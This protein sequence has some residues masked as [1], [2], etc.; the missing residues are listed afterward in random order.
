MPHPHGVEL[1][2]LMQMLKDTE[3]RTVRSALSDDF[4]RVS[5]RRR[6]IY[7]EGRPRSE[8]EPDPH[9]P[10]RKRGTLPGDPG[11]QAD[12]SADGLPVADR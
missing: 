8:G 4:S 11:H 9:R 1:G 2:M 6:W 3:T 7:V 10:P 5:R 12:A